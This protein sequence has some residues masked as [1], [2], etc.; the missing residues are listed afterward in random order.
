MKLREVTTTL[1]KGREKALVAFLTAGYPDQT[2]FAELVRAAAGAG[3]DVIEIGIPFSDPIADGPLIQQ[4]SQQ[5]LDA[6]MSLGKSLDI[7]AA[8]SAQIDTPLVVMSYYNPILQMGNERFAVR[9]AEAGISGV[10]IPDMPVEESGTVRG[11]FSQN[12][13]VYLDLIAPTSSDDRIGRIVERADGF[14]YLVSV[15]GV[16]GV[17]SPAA[18][19]LKRFTNRV[20]AR[21]GLPLYVGF[22][23]SDAEKARTAART[24]D[25]VIIGSALVRLIHSAASGEEAVSSVRAFLTDVKKALSAR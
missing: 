8:L 12:D 9:A 5:A 6:G 16:T 4:S 10:I 2:T 24:A 25:G 19:D 14:L 20:R 21:T 7:V 11:I 17:R 3:C 18:E 15:T 1:K 13:V 22:G 23:I